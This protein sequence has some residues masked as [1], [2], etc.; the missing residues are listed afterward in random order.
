MRPSAWVL[1]RVRGFPACRSVTESQR[2]PEPSFQFVHLGKVGT[3]MVDKDW[4]SP[5][6]RT[7]QDS[8]AKSLKAQKQLSYQL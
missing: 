1:Q 2:R 8:G 7:G 4:M 6:W 3:K 5:Q